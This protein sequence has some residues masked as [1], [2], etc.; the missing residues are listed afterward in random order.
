MLAWSA[1][2]CRYWCGGCGDQLSKPAVRKGDKCTGHGDAKP[3]ANDQGSPDVFINSKAAHRQGD[4]WKIHKHHDSRLVRGSSTVFVNGKGQARVGD[5]ILC[6]SRCATGSPNVFVGDS[7]AGAGG[8]ASQGAASAPVDYTNPYRFEGGAGASGYSGSGTVDGEGGVQDGNAVDDPQDGPIDAS[9]DD[10][11]WLTTCMMDE[12]LNQKSSDAWAAVAQVVVTRLRTGK[13]A[14]QINSAWR[15]KIKGVVLATDQFSGFYFDMI[16]RRYTRV[17]ARGNWAAVETRGKR[18]MARYRAYSQWAT[19]HRVAQQVVD[20]TY[21]GGAAWRL[22]KNRPATMYCNLAVSRPA[23][24]T[25]SNY[26]TKIEDH[27]FFRT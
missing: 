24:G 20:G 16:N 15:G 14:G 7:G 18:K 19:F 4:H 10:V 11:D 8:Q 25:Q 5:P 6:G 21:Q 23:W 2:E 17:V 13:N 22:V 27:T 9:D 1:T 3:R 26:I 12:A